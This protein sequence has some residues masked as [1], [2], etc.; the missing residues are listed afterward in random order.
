MGSPC[1]SRPLFWGL[2]W[3]EPGGYPFCCSRT[4]VPR[5]LTGPFL[6]KYPDLVEIV[7]QGMNH[8]PHLAK[9]WDKGF[10]G[11]P[12]FIPCIPR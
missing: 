1:F 8:L 10:Q 4:K 12:V 6:T 11:R 7:S 9:K 2:S 5:S 3:G